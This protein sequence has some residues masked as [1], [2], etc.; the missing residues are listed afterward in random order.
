MERNTK[1][2]ITVSIIA[3]LGITVY[4]FR[5]KIFGKTQSNKVVVR[6]VTKEA[7]QNTVK[8]VKS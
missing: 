3:I 8:F 2:I 5:D 1:I 4:A 7:K 6:G